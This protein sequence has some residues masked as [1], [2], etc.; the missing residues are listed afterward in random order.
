MLR[1]QETPTAKHTTQ[2]YVFF[3][4]TVYVQTSL[5]KLQDGTAIF[6]EFRHWKAKKQKASGS[7]LIVHALISTSVQVARG[8]V[9]LFWGGEGS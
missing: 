3:E 6:F 5:N 7:R 8:R 1:A 9:V 2:Q 4:D